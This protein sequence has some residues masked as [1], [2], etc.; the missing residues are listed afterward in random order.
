MYERGYATLCKICTDNGDDPL[1]EVD[2]RGPDETHTGWW[3]VWYEGH[4]D[5]LEY[6][7][8]GFDARG[9][10]G[11]TSCV[12]VALFCFWCKLSKLD[13]HRCSNDVRTITTHKQLQ[14]V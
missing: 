8:D 11:Y 4:P 3:E 7:A 6:W 12:I 13:A 5:A 10:W 1:K 9:E 14:N 2:I